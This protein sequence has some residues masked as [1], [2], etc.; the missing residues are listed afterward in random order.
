MFLVQQTM[1]HE[2]GRKDL[3]DLELLIYVIHVIDSDSHILSN[4]WA[5]FQETST[6]VKY[7]SRDVMQEP[8]TDNRFDIAKDVIYTEYINLANE[9][10][11]Y[12]KYLPLALYIVLKSYYADDDIGFEMNMNDLLRF[13]SM[14]RVDINDF[15]ENDGTLPSLEVLIDKLRVSVDSSR[16]P[17]KIQNL[18]KGLVLI[19]HKHIMMTFQKYEAFISRRFELNIDKD[20]LEL[21]NISDNA[22]NITTYLKTRKWN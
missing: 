5:M 4:F 14:E 21:L 8:F 2:D 20:I 22:E 12:M 13:S 1:S 15:L 9:H 3:D 16:H 7:L 6:Y 10:L 17:L 19:Y 18:D 11:V